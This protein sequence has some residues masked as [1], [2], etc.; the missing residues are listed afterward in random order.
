MPKNTTCIFCNQNR[1]KAKEHIWPKWLQIYLNG[2]LLEQYQGT[3]LSST[4]G[5][6]ISQRNQN[7]ST[8]VCGN[9]CKICNNGWMNDLESAFKPIYESIHQNYSRLSHLNKEERNTIAQWGYKTGLVINAGSNYRKIVPDKHYSSFYK[10]K[11]IPKNI[12]IDIAK[13]DSDK[14]LVW[15]QSNIFSS[16]VSASEMDKFDPYDMVKSSYVITMQIGHLGIRISYYKDCK[17]LGYSL[18]NNENKKVLRI[19]PYSANCGFNI[20]NALDSILS[21][22]YGAHINKIGLKKI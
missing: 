18:P 13:I 9:V 1:E 16:T 8:L 22:H 11:I 21:F 6:I 15:E 10:N 19:R 2:S 17:K 3:H 4:P 20:Y 7:G 5:I 14:L 12:K